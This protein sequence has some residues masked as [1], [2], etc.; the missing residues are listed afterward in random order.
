MDLRR[1]IE[2]GGASGGFPRNGRLIA[3]ITRDGIIYD[4]AKQHEERS[5]VALHDPLNPSAIPE[6]SYA[7]KSSRRMI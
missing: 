7:A 2:S 5:M 3:R 4:E 6:A 1:A